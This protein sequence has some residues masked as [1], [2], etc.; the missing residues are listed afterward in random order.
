MSVLEFE[1]RCSGSMQAWVEQPSLQP[2]WVQWVRRAA[3][4][5]ELA[6]ALLVLDAHLT[7]SLR[8]RMWGIERSAEWRRNA[9]GA[10]DTMSD[11]VRR[12]I[13]LDECCNWDWVEKDLLRVA[14]ERPAPGSGRE[15]RFW[16]LGGVHVLDPFRVQQADHRRPPHRR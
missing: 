16:A 6:L 7:P 13:E 14:S 3:V 15:A 4:P 11:V 1:D 9:A 10:S 2:A 12:L 8:T 5:R